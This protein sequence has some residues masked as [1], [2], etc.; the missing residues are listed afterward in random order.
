MI[1]KLIEKI[2]T[3]YR[4]HKY[5]LAYPEVATVSGILVNGLPF[6]QTV[7]TCVVCDKKLSLDLCEMIDLPFDMARGCPGRKDG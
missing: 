4:K 3:H 1:F 6:Q 5:D 2:K 7:F